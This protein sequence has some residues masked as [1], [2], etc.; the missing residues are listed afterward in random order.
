[1]RKRFR[2]I[3]FI[4]FVALFSLATTGCVSRLGTGWAGLTVLENGNQVVYAYE[5]TLAI[6]D[7]VEGE[8]IPITDASGEAQINEDGEPVVWQVNGNDFDNAKF[9]A[10]PLQYNEDSILVTT[11]DRRLMRFNVDST[12]AAVVSDGI[13]DARGNAIADLTQADGKVFLGLQERFVALDRESLSPQ[14]QIPTSHGVWAQP[15]LRDEMAYFAS[16]DHN[17]YAVNIESGEIDWTL[18]LGGAAT[19]TPVF[20]PDQNVFFVGTFESKVLKISLEGDIVDDFD[21]SEWVWGAPT[22]IDGRLYVADLGGFVYNLDPESMDVSGGWERQ[23]A[24]GAIRTPPLVFD[25]YVVVASRDQHVY[26]LDRDSGA[27]IFS[28]QLDGE[29]LSD[30]L[31]FS[32]DQVDDLEENIVVV[33]TLSDRESLVAFGAEN[34]ERIWTYRR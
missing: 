17:M 8:P 4:L 14:W 7:V 29:I 15:F 6:V 30:I 34:G 18:D 23:V 12:E 1:L 25:D 2:G 3:G 26:W 13:E 33:S 32:T 22:L 27:E 5:N 16:L 10:A 19:A 21:T 9:F 31:Y 20:D 11:L 24:E 28:R